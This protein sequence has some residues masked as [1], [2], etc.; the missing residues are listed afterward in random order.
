[1]TF[2]PHAKFP[3]ENN[4]KLQLFR[5]VINTLVKHGWLLTDLMMCASDV[6]HKF[7]KYVSRVFES[8]FYEFKTEL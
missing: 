8:F 5:A 3:T 4:S 2:K 6:R 7:R 1:M